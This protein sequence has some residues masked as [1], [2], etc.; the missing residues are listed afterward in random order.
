MQLK[1]LLRGQIE[2]RQFHP[3]DRIPSEQELAEAHGITRMTAR[4]AIDALIMEDVLFRQPGKGTFVAQDKMPAPSVLSSFS[5]MM[6]SLGLSVSSKVID[7][8]LVP[9][10]D[11]VMHDLQLNEPQDVVFLRR[12]RYVEGEPMA[13]HAS[14]M[15]SH[16]FTR[17][18]D[19]DLAHRPLSTIMEEASGLHIVASR[20]YVEA[21]LAQAD[22]AAMLGIRKRAP[23]LLVRGVAY[24]RDEQPIRSSKGVYRGD[25]FRFCVAAQDG[26]TAVQA[27]GRSLGATDHQEQWQ[28]LMPGMGELE[29]FSTRA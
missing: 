28:G 27:Q 4:R 17:I 8:R 15:L 25:R 9:A 22:E 20:D 11:H 13:L 14:Y 7:L 19:A 29:A 24:A 26:A 18:L 21:A 23:V 3:G 6:H 2:S 1:E 16:Y 12:I 5:T 10:P